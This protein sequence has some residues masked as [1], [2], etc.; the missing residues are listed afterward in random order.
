MLKPRS[1]QIVIT[2]LEASAINDLMKE[3]IIQM[4]RSHDG[5]WMSRQIDLD[6]IVRMQKRYEDILN[7]IRSKDNN[8]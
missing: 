6:M 4:V 8:G 2:E 5:D 3:K 7:Y 1:K